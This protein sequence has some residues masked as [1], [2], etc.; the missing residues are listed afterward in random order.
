MYLGTNRGSGYSNQANSMEKEYWS[1]ELSD[2]QKQSVR[3]YIATLQYEATYELPEFP[4]TPMDWACQTSE[5]MAAMVEKV[6][7]G[8]GRIHAVGPN[9]TASDR[10]EHLAFREEIRQRLIARHSNRP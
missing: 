5:D 7:L 4:D 3:N 2:E 6:Q 10:V 9:S 1:E 8:G